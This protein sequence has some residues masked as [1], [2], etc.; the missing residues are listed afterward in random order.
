MVSFF[1]S[2]INNVLNYIYSFFNLWLLIK[3]Y[4][5]FI[6][7]FNIIYDITDIKKPRYK[8]QNIFILS[9]LVINIILKPMIFVN[10]INKWKTST[11]L[12]YTKLLSILKIKKN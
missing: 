2:I 10:S 12:L 9:I 6:D 11:E 7:Y 8:N 3:F 1:A 4:K 5:W